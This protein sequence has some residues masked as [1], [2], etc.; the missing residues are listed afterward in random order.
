[1]HFA[2]RTFPDGKEVKVEIWQGQATFIFTAP[3]EAESIILNL[4]QTRKEIA[5]PTANHPGVILSLAQRDANSGFIGS[6]L[7][8]AL[9]VFIAFR[10]SKFS[11]SKRSH[12]I[13]H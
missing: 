7:V 2:E 6:A 13:I 12:A 4:N 11:F 1:L 9:T 3:D 5:V 8:L 10:L